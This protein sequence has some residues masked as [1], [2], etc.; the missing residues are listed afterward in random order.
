MQFEG[1]DHYCSGMFMKFWYATLFK[2]PDV[3]ERDM[4]ITS[5]NSRALHELRHG[6]DDVAQAITLSIVRP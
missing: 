5:V 2:V 4:P 3:R 6:A 1:L